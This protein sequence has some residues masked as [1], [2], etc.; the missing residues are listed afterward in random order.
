MAQ[1]ETWLNQDMMQAVKVRYLDG[2]LFS[3]DNAG[4]LI[5]VK[6]TRD[7]EDYSGGGTVSANVIRAD[8]GTVAVT[9]ALSGNV[10]TVV[11]PQSAYAVPGVVSIVVKLT[12]SG[13]IITIAAVVANIYQSSTETA[14]DPGTIIP[15]IQTLIN[16]ISTAV[17]SIPADYSSLWATLA[18]AFSTSTAYTAGQYVTYNGGLYRFTADHAAG[19]WSSSDVSSA[20][21]GN[22][23]GNKA[24]KNNP[25]FTGNVS[26]GR[27]GTAGSGSVALGSS[28]EAS[29][30]GSFAVG[31][32][33]TA[34]GSESFA[35]G[36]GTTASGTAS[37][38]AGEGTKAT[39]KYQ[40]VFGAYN[41]V[42]PSTAAS[43]AKGT[44]VEIVGNGTDNADNKRSNARTLDWNG[45][46]TLSGDLTVNK[47]TANEVTLGSEVSNLKN[48]INSL[49]KEN[50]DTFVATR[51]ISVVENGFYLVDE[52]YNIALEIDSLLGCSNT[53]IKIKEPGIIFVDND[54]N[55]GYVLNADALNYLNT[56]YAENKKKHTLNGTWCSIG[57]S[58]TWYNDHPV[59]RMT[60]GYQSR[61][62]EVIDVDTLY[63]IGWNGGTIVQL[64]TDLQ[65]IV[66]ADLYTIEHGVNDWGHSTPVGTRSDYVNNTGDGTFYGCYRI[67]IDKI[68]EQNPKAKIILC[69]PR[70]AYG[71]NG[72]LPET[73]ETPK[74]NIYLR[75]YADAVKEI[76][77]IESIPV[78]DWFG[79]SGVNDRNLQSY[80]IDD[81]LHPNDAGMQIMADKL[82]ESIESIL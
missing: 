21:I 42:D 14:I 73:S 32:A 47:G 1:I 80:S 5:G 7:G 28:A 53:I 13:A 69:T 41:T 23:L 16:Q 10:A 27:Y 40:H 34:S 48:A 77:E 67:V 44:Y 54:L 39:H 8:G 18:P 61:V 2:N 6:L 37:H 65:R 75:E 17:A 49:P 24:D 3:Q 81:A 26:M 22:E 11:L 36:R 9:G 25:V 66:E 4:N 29:G 60:K 78:C 19:A 79:S 63:N 33:T 72:Y 68:Y 15:S 45:N 59:S 56:A 50:R 57:T 74:N 38:A 58:I 30:G 52:N 43:T 35:E 62:M 70:K 64:T 20:V 71:F 76:A 46:E 12:V 55:I 51:F 31:S 82:I